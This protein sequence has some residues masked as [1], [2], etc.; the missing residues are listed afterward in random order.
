MISE[1]RAFYEERI[2]YYDFDLGNALRNMREFVVHHYQVG[3]L[4]DDYD[5]AY[6]GLLLTVYNWIYNQQRV[7]TVIH[8]VS[9]LF[10]Y[11][12][13]QQVLPAALPPL[14]DVDY[15]PMA[16]FDP[17]GIFARILT[18]DPETWVDPF[19][20]QGG[21]TIKNLDSEIASTLK[22]EGYRVTNLLRDLNSRSNGINLWVTLDPS[23][24]ST[25]L[26]FDSDAAKTWIYQDL[27]WY[28]FIVKSSLPSRGVYTVPE[29]P[30]FV[31]RA[32]TEMEDYGI[33]VIENQLEVLS[34]GL[35]TPGL[36]FL[37]FADINKLTWNSSDFQYRSSLGTVQTVT[38]AAGETTWTGARQYIYWV[39]GETFLRVT[40]NVDDIGLNDPVLGIYSG[41]STFERRNGSTLITGDDI[42]TATITAVNIQTGS[43]TA[44][45][46]KADETF[47]QNLYLGGPE[48]NLNG[49]NKIITIKDQQLPPITRVRMGKIGANAE[50]FGIEIYDGN[51][52]LILSSG[53]GITP[54]PGTFG[55]FA[56]L[57]VLN[58]T[59]I[60]TYIAAAAISDAYIGNL[61][62]VKIIADSTFTQ[63]LFIGD[64]HIQLDGPNTRIS[65]IDA[66]AVPVE[67]V[68]I[69][70]LGPAAD[71]YGISIWD[72]SGN[73]ILSSGSPNPFPTLGAMAFINSITSANISTFIASAAISTAYIADA[74]ITNAKIATLDAAKID[75]GFL[76]ADRI[77]ALSI[78]VSKLRIGDTTNL[79]P[80]PNFLLEN[81]GD[82][83]RNWVGWNS[84]FVLVD[85]ATEVGVPANTK[86][87]LV[88][89]I[90]GNMSTAGVY[91][92]PNTIPIQEGQKLTLSFD[93]SSNTAI[94]LNSFKISV[95]FLLKNGTTTIVDTFYVPGLATW[96]TYNQD[97][98][99]I[100]NSIG[101]KVRV[102]R[103]T[104]TNTSNIYAVNFRIRNK[105]NEIL[106]EDGSIT[107][108]KVAAGTV[109][110]QALYVGENK[111]II[112][113]PNSMFR[114][115]DG[116]YDRVKIGKLGVG[117]Y[118]IEIYKPDGTLLLSSSSGIPSGA[119]SGLG[120]FAFIS[121]ID[122]SNISTFIASAA[123]GT[124]Y[125]ADAAINN[126]K[127]SDLDAAKIN[128][129]TLDAARIAAS[130]I[131]VEK[132]SFQN[133]AFTLDGLE[134]MY[135][136]ATNKVWWPTGGTA[137]YFDD[138]GIRQT[139]S[140]AAV[141]FAGAITWSTGKIYIF[142]NSTFPTVLQSTTNAAAAYASNN[143]IV[144]TYAGGSLFTR[145]E[146]RVIIDGN[147]DIRAGSITAD[148]IKS[149]EI[150]TQVLYLGSTSFMLDGSGTNRTITIKDTQAVPVNRVIIGKLGALATDWGIQVY[151]SAGQLILGANGLGVNVVSTG[152][153]VDGS[154]TDGKVNSLTASK[155]T[156]GTL[157]AAVIDIKDSKFRLDGPNQLMSVT[158]NQTIPVTRVRLGK[159]GSGTTAYGIEIYN[160]DGSV[161]LN[162]GGLGP[163]VITISNLQVGTFDN[164][165]QNPNFDFGITGWTTDFGTLNV[166]TSPFSDSYGA[167]IAQIDVRTSSSHLGPARIDVIPGETYQ[168]EYTIRSTSNINAGFNA[169]VQFYDKTGALLS[170][171]SG[172]AN[173]VATYNT[174]QSAGWVK[175]QYKITVP[176]NAKQMQVWSY[177]GANAA[178]LGSWYVS[179][180]YINKQKD[181]VLIQD[182]AITAAK[183]A[184]GEIFTQLLYVGENKIIL[185]GPQSMIR[186][187]DGT[188]DRVK[189]G[190]LATSSYGIDIINAAGTSVFRSDNTQTYLQGSIV[191]D[192]SLTAAKIAANEVFT[193]KLYIGSTIA[194][195]NITLD[196]PNNQITIKDNQGSP[197]TRVLLGKFDGTVTGYGLKVYNTLG[198]ETFNTSGLTYNA[199][200]ADSLAT[201][202]RNSIGGVFRVGFETNTDISGD[203]IFIVGA[204]E[205]V[206]LSSTEV[207]SGTR[208]G[209]YT[210]SVSSRNP[211]G[212][213]SGSAIVIED[214]FATQFV[215][216]RIRVTCYAKRGTAGANSFYIS[217]SPNFS[218]QS[219]GWIKCNVTNTA[220]SKIQFDYDVPDTDTVTP[221]YLGIWAYNSGSQSIYID[222]ISIRVVDRPS[223]VI[224]VSLFAGQNGDIYNYNDT[225]SGNKPTNPP[226]SAVSKFGLTNAAI[227]ATQTSTLEVIPS[228]TIQWQVFLS[229]VNIEYTS[230]TITIKLKFYGAD[231]VT[232]ITTPTVRT[233]TFDPDLIGVWTEYTGSYVVPANALYVA[234]EMTISAGPVGGTGL[235]GL[236]RF[237]YFSGAIMKFEAALSDRTITS[238]KMIM[239]DTSN[240]VNNPDFRYGDIGF[241]KGLGWTIISS[242]SNSLT[243][244]YVARHVPVPLGG[245]AFASSILRTEN[246]N[247]IP[248][249]EGEVVS[250]ASIL[251]FSSD[252]AT[253]QSTSYAA[254]VLVQFT[255]ASGAIL[256]TQYTYVYKDTAW[257]K[258]DILYRAPRN[259][260]SCG[261]GVEILTQSAGTA[262]V[263]FLSTRKRFEPLQGVDKFNMV[264]NHDFRYSDQYWIKEPSWKIVYD[265]VNAYSGSRVAI[266]ASQG[267]ASKTESIRPEGFDRI[268]VQ[269]GDRFYIEAA[270]KIDASANPT[271]RIYVHY[272]LYDDNLTTLTGGAIGGLDITQDTPGSDIWKIYF[273]SLTIST[274]LPTASY[275]MLRV[276]ATGSFTGSVYL[277]RFYVTKG[278]NV[279]AITLNYGTITAP[280]I[281]STDIST[282]GWWFDSVGIGMVVRGTQVYKASQNGVI[283]FGPA[284]GASSIP[285]GLV[286]QAQVSAYA[287]SNSYTSGTAFAAVVDNA[288]TVTGGG[289]ALYVVQNADTSAKTTALI[290]SRDTNFTGTTLRLMS[291]KQGATDFRHIATTDSAGSQVNFEVWG[292]GHV[293]ANWFQSLRTGS[294]VGAPTTTTR[295]IGTR[296]VL[297]STLSSTLV[298]Y[299]IGHESSNMWFSV[300]DSARNFKWYAGTTQ[301]AQLT[302][303][304]NLNLTAS[305]AGIGIG[306]VAA[307][308]INIYAVMNPA[309]VA[310]N[311]TN[312]YTGLNV[313]ISSYDIANGVADSGAR[314]GVAINML[315]PAAALLGTL[316][317][318]HGISVNYGGGSSTA[319]G[320]I[321]D[322]YG[323]QLIYSNTGSITVTRPWGV[324]Q[325]GS[326]AVNRFDG[327]VGI[328]ESTWSNIV[329]S[330]LL[331][332]GLD[333]TAVSAGTNTRYG[334]Q[335]VTS[336]MLTNINTGVVD[337]G[338]RYGISVNAI[339][340]D[341][342]FKGTLSNQYGLFVAG[343]TTTG[344]TGTVTNAYLSYLQGNVTGSTVTNAWGL[345]QTGAA[346]NNYMEAGLFIGST[347]PPANTKFMTTGGSNLLNG[348]TFINSGASSLPNVSATSLRDLVVGSS[349]NNA[350]TGIVI[351]GSNSAAISFLN[352]EST[353]AARITYSSGG[354]MTIRANTVDQVTLNGS[355]MTNAGLFQTNFGTVAGPSHSFINAPDTGM[356]YTTS[357]LNF[358][359]G[360]TL[361]FQVNAT[362]AT[363]FASN[364]TAI[365]RVSR[366]DTT[367][368]VGA[369]TGQVDFYYNNSSGTTAIQQSI[370]R[371]VANGITAGAEN[372]T[373]EFYTRRA[374]SLTRKVWIDDVLNGDGSGLTNLNAATLTGTVPNASL[375]GSYTNITSL[376]LSAAAP[377]ISLIETDQTSPDGRYRIRMQ[378]GTLEFLNNTAVAGDF[379][380]G[381]VDFSL[382]SST[383]NVG[384]GGAANP[385]EKLR[386][387]S[388]FAAATVNQTTTAYTVRITSPTVAVSSGV[389]ESGSRINLSI[390]GILTNATLVG[391]LANLYGIY[392]EYGENTAAGGTG[393]I[394]NAYGLY[395]NYVETGAATIT[396]K[397][398]IYQAGS[399]VTNYFAGN[400]TTDGTVTATGAITGASFSGSGASLTALNATQL[401]S[402]TVPSGRLAGAY[403]GITQ[404]GTLV[405][406]NV[407]N[408]QNATIQRR[409]GVA[410]GS[411]VPDHTG[412]SVDNL[413]IGDGSTNFGMMLYAT[414]GYITWA[415]T[416]S[417]NPAARMLFDTAAN[418]W[419]FQ[420]NNST[421]ITF[422]N[423]GAITAA[424]FSGNGASL[425]ALN[426]TQLTSGTVPS[427]AIA[428]SY[429]GITAI[430][431]LNT[432]T[433][434]NTG[435]SSS[436]L[437]S[438]HAGTMTAGTKNAALL[439][440][441]T[442]NPTF[443]GNLTSTG[444]SV[445]NN[446]TTTAANQSSNA[447]TH[448][449]VLT[450]VSTVTSVGG[451]TTTSLYGA[452]HIATNGASDAS[453]NTIAVIAGTRSRVVSGHANA[454]ST[455]AY[456]VLSE[457]VMTA[458]S[459]GT[460]FLFQGQYTGAGTVTSKWGIYI[461]GETANYLSSTLRVGTVS[462]PSVSGAVIYANGKA[463]FTDN[464]TIT[465]AAGQSVGLVLS[466]ASS[467]NVNIQYT[468]T[469]NTTY[470]GVSGTDLYF[471]SSATTTSNNLVYHAGNI[472][473]VAKLQGK[474]SAYFTPKSDID[475]YSTAPCAT[476]ARYNAA[477]GQ[478]DIWT[479]DFDTTTQEYA[480]FMWRPPKNWNGGTITFQIEWI[481][482]AAA[483][484]NR[485]AW[486]LEGLAVGDGGAINA[487]FGTAVV[488]TDGASTGGAVNTYYIS[489]ESTAVTLAGTP[490]NAKTVY[491]RVSRVTG[492]AGDVMT[493]DACLALVRIYYTTNAANEA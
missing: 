290:Y 138:S 275:M 281:Q 43:L 393:T 258:V 378:N 405:G 438:T 311:A 250:V 44:D 183:V 489:A 45:L 10:N 17:T 456:G 439:T 85:S 223:N 32:T 298:D 382:V 9:A 328:G 214:S 14:N 55:Q 410:S 414:A 4:P 19:G 1:N 206:T 18:A 419:Q 38:V 303:S 237:W 276:I 239:D 60:S 77:D 482:K 431:T 144:A 477:N 31:P 100:T 146:G 273:A 344:A 124:A 129:G 179:Q 430:G 142:W 441:T 80:N 107:A 268:E 47:T 343:G 41:G 346:W 25:Y 304:G 209:L 243:N 24:V 486:S 465:M 216:R 118:G 39:P 307:T 211:Y 109:F 164:L 160:A 332:R 296:L 33:T 358:A 251:K 34:M 240:F 42:Q 230:V 277:G 401:T 491:F 402:G 246:I 166:I 388:N 462:G 171:P 355:V 96:T 185:D 203:P 116:T 210:S 229:P 220:W 173:P 426:A 134:F 27:G 272:T 167:K 447:S 471:G 153:I 140:V 317:T 221:H 76:S 487:N 394:T 339:I 130:S 418:N 335:V 253:T 353:L 473:T 128:T 266:R 125:I 282:T 161:L 64:N 147:G 292:D 469:T 103:L 278:G 94:T 299:A 121:Q 300:P 227:T 440:M 2:S 395:L 302:G 291:N 376:A 490:T 254:R 244:T 408:T 331:V 36:Q 279:P 20:V 341:S 180:V 46:I 241:N 445:V 29:H 265:T 154:V 269:P 380:T 351:I 488:V 476:V 66:Q 151:D 403:T 120:A 115:N 406:L 208:S 78:D 320:T 449:G 217:Y 363:N 470:L 8:T 57:N 391:T 114:V 119:I 442:S 13:M 105:I 99:G 23:V 196:G 21:S 286:G 122:L 137:N 71:Q 270:M 415:S 139:A 313:S 387:N 429:T 126:A 75:T 468:S 148:R 485:V 110:T 53:T 386:I 198:Q 333:A 86:S 493:V 3:Q 54:S 312:Q 58:A 385:T 322:S 162:A 252:F 51:G 416:L 141:V 457:I 352:S 189:I 413:V 329:N 309:A 82:T 48:F 112:D 417:G 98:V 113:G 420:I 242:P 135:D 92:H 342:N 359:V 143:I 310:A 464:L 6:D 384:I 263:G 337:S 463:E 192:G 175:Q 117:N 50:D 5:D 374:G 136:P 218:T 437:S 256:T 187:N 257:N 145:E 428:G 176:A 293:T 88:M 301:I 350:N 450:N 91:M 108:P 315:P 436:A 49:P 16:L 74:A 295:S 451:S 123:I 314:S 324:S 131:T 101:M 427:A 466:R 424:S 149:N 316:G 7:H 188:R 369:I 62:A 261:A 479:L 238:S 481:Q 284:T 348:Q 321:N 37:K 133:R 432:L 245:G 474:E 390:H 156:T 354:T 356:Y 271:T 63:R 158:D 330:K 90:F 409:L 364:A 191:V 73:L 397:Y 260:V 319:T 228:D 193:Q 219:S 360:G 377:F 336:F 392:T 308:N 182:G 181:S 235:D 467:A 411:S 184:A 372:N 435:A 155:L 26:N 285:I 398:G 283:M 368:T 70:K 163:G 177:V 61:N 178:P 259:S 200:I 213:T 345:Y 106:I 83:P 65:I 170:T 289:T 444:L 323:L 379:S 264:T 104:N 248:V 366:S 400:I 172:V 371:N 434:N 381:T 461:T 455:T 12:R 448:Y 349:A 202:V 478:P 373:I 236:T 168:I 226:T 35:L 28:M 84:A 68:R 224:P 383:G 231:S 367:A 288:A 361:A 365:Y 93:V 325:Q 207:F 338:N 362:V 255:D 347:T 222:N 274:S 72:A 475:P 262:Y 205:T 190:K 453:D 201:I 233:V 89:K 152:Q 169:S 150:L 204:S 340:S 327:P 11:R 97:I 157:T 111:I 306:S 194:T 452:W 460:G 186:V 22:Y 370:I 294:S 305:T 425:T 197:V 69:G 247:N 454:V 280:T 40:T 423:T 472:A 215:G 199:T 165:A 375:V 459:V 159:L 174:Q 297:T 483:A 396:N 422:S 399:T 234:V 225:D 95:E 81:A 484:D 132:L 389:V 87:K 127:I 232:V 407:D 334:I 412:T 267:D 421:V 102:V 318:Q 492:N 287:T 15:T 433:I 195:Q 357:N 212:N 443:T 67:R 480:S 52:D 30:E 56:Y 446:V 458:G 404:V 249:V 79:V 59:N 326:A